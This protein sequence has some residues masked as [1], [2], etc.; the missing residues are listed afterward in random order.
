[1]LLLKTYQQKYKKTRFVKIRHKI[2]KCIIIMRVIKV[3]ILLNDRNESYC[4]M[5]SFITWYLI[6]IYDFYNDISYEIRSEDPIIWKRS[7]SVES[8]HFPNHKNHCC[9]FLQKNES[10]WCYPFT[11]RHLCSILHN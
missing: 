2:Q 10:R 11:I 1:M 3:I 9:T 8:N 6:L 7:P 4:S 5:M